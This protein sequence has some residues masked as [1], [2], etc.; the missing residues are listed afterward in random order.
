MSEHS[1][2]VEADLARYYPRDAD[3]LNAF[4]RG[5]MSIRRLHVLVSRLPRDSATHAVRVGGRGH[6][7]WDDHTELMAG[8]IEELRRFQLLFRQAN[9]DP[10]KSHTLP[11]DID[12]VP[13]PW[14]D[15]TTPE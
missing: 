14:N 15:E 13:R 7:D 1:E 5:E 10:K 8:V 4:F 9:T 11:R 2:D 6:A 12:Y 3:Q